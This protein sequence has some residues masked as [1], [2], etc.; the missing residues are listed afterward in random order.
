[1]STTVNTGVKWLFL[2]C[3]LS[4]WVFFVMRALRGVYFFASWSRCSLR[5]SGAVEATM[6]VKLES[7]QWSQEYRRQAGTSGIHNATQ[8]VWYE[9]ERETMIKKKNKAKKYPIR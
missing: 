5:E 8:D 4:S 1:M 6:D 7:T 3:H 2:S 9:S